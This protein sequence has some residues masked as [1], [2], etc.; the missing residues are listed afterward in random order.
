MNGVKWWNE[1]DDS[2]WAERDGL[3]LIIRRHTVG[4]YIRFV[5]IDHRRPNGDQDM[6]IGSGTREDIPTA[7]E[8]AE[9]MATRLAITFLG[10]QRCGSRAMM[11]SGSRRLGG[12]RSSPA[13]R[14]VNTT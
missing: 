1:G 4:G 10:P 9:R 7:K 8:A 11:A 2:L 12:W 13:A 6:L 14:R 3:R 5:V